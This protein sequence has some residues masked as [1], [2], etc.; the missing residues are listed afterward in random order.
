M[1]ETYDKN[2]RAYLEHTG[3]YY[4]L[5]EKAWVDVP[6]A[7]TYD[8]TE[9]AWV[10]R[11][12]AGYF[13][14]VNDSNYTSLQSGD[15]LDVKSNGFVFQTFSKNLLRKVKFELPYKWKHGDI[16]E[17]DVVTN[18]R[19]YINVE[20]EYRYLK[21]GTQEWTVGGPIANRTG[22]YNEHIT[23]TM[24]GSVPDTYEGWQ[25]TESII[26]IQSII[27]VDSATGETYSEIKN[28]TING[29]KYGFKE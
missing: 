17:F 18:A 15:I 13:T 16:F 10:E 6:S 26:E 1:F 4:D 25:V 21:Y 7:M 23:Y 20:R 5:Q 27:T 12:Y 29:K 28:F 19:G 24:S 8:K 3:Q 9:K 11:L 2:Q 14:L 22:E